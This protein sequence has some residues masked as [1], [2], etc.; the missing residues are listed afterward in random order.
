[1]LRLRLAMTALLLCSCFSKSNP[2]EGIFLENGIIQQHL[3]VAGQTADGIRVRGFSGAVPPNAKLNFQIETFAKAIEAD[4]NGR[5]DIVLNLSSNY[6]DFKA[7]TTTET[8]S[9]RFR[10]K[11]V[12]DALAKM[13]VK[14][15]P[16][17]QYPQDILIDL[18]V[19]EP[20]AYVASTGENAIH[21]IPLLN[22]DQA[23]SFKLKTSEINPWN[24]S[25]YPKD[26][27]RLLATL[28]DSH[29][30]IEIS[31]ANAKSRTFFQANTHPI[32]PLNPLVNLD[33]PKDLLFDG[34]LKNL[35]SEMR[36]RHP[37]AILSYGP[38]LLVAF[39][40]YLQ[41]AFGTQKG[42]SG[43]GS[44]ALFEQVGND[45]IFRHSIQINE[46]AN[47]SALTLDNDNQPWLSCTGIYE[48]DSD[49]NLSRSSKSALVKLG[50]HPHQSI[51]MFYIP[52]IDLKG[53][54]PEKPIFIDDKI[55]LGNQ[56]KAEIAI[57]PINATALADDKIISISN[58]RS[59]VANLTKIGGD[60]I[61][62]TDSS[63]DRLLVFDA[64]T[65]EL[66]PW[67]FENGIELESGTTVTKHLPTRITSFYPK[68]PSVDYHHPYDI[69]IST[70]LSS[71]LFALSL[72][73]LMGPI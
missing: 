46:C 18:N 12:N 1:L 7:E 41:Y 64:H 17:G 35:A 67:P 3:I 25:F 43:P 32:I 31:F 60:L 30:L 21:R 65:Q 53:F 27:S 34:N 71:Q 47:P 70:G 37:S 52:I 62:L 10:V 63:N 14:Q 2:Q 11:N 56:I 57:L 6:V 40:N 42:L 54:A 22:P 36:L 50:I 61:L 68:K 28:Y 13:L 55:I 66:S 45:F 16:A 9:V 44:V 59:Y 8:Q 29:D 39:S 4:T 15:W 19:N 48:S 72:L 69:I 51:L 33:A 20:V 23:Q 38:W 73:Q 5:F 24:L 26:P 58:K 49:G